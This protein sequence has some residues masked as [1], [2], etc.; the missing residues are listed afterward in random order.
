MHFPT[1]CGIVEQVNDQ[2]QIPAEPDR[3]SVDIAD[4]H[5][6]DSRSG[7]ASSLKNTLSTIGFL[8]IAPAIAF[9]LTIYVF[10]SYQVDGP[11]MQNTLHNGDRLIVWKLPRTWARI[12]GH[13]YVPKRGDII[14]FTETGLASYGDSANTKQLVK[15]VIGLPGDHVVVKNGV[16][17]IYNKTH[18]NG[19][20]P[21]KA[22][23]YGKD[24]AIPPTADNVD[25][26]LS[27]T[28]LFV[29]GDNRGDSLDSRIF[30]PIETKDVIGKL[31]LRVLPLSDLE[32]F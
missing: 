1:D 31:V 24:G 15:R 3:H 2:N 11:S 17:T 22:L 13:Q 20:Q 27:P 25:V 29:C 14:I 30:G 23:P 6:P 28:Q 26:T 32:R 8:L 9:F 19:F 5:T 21:D 16:I 18:P 12:T 4:V 7:R 10:Q